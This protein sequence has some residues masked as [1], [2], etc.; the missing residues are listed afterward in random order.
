MTVVLFFSV[1]S[2]LVPLVAFFFFLSRYYI[3]RHQFIFVYTPQ[4]SLGGKFWFEMFYYT[5]QGLVLFSVTM[6]LYTALKQGFWQSLTLLPLP[7]VV[8]YQWGR[9]VAT[10]GKVCDNMIIHYCVDYNIYYGLIIH[11]INISNE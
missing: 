6:L 5:M 2:P 8:W 3:L 9:M 7:A 4:Y 1:I 11:T 10:F